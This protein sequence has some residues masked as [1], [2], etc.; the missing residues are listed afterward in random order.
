MKIFSKIALIVIATVVGFATQ[1]CEKSR[2]Y[3]E[4]L[5]DENMAV[6]R[7]LA[8]QWV[9]ASIPADTVFLVGPDAPYY[10][11]D[12]DGNIYMQVL[13]AG[14]GEKAE[15]DQQI[16]FRFL[17]YNLSTY[18]GDMDALYSEGNQNDMAQSSTSFRY[19]NYTLPSSSK[20]GSGIQLPLAYLPLNCHINLVVKSQFGWTNEV[21][22][23][24]PYLYNV[25]YYQSQI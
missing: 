19:G 13:D 7:F 10:Q 15:V 24:V 12:E 16:Y 18:S 21:S 11:L 4:L 5:N 8:D 20:W 1:S 17:R 14:Y 6:N 22:Y 23:V 9:I 2:S 25:R 3:S